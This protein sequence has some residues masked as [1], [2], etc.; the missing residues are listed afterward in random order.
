MDEKN[1]KTPELS[2]ELENTENL[3]NAVDEK[4]TTPA[5]EKPVAEKATDSESSEMSDELDEKS[6][7]ALESFLSRDTSDKK[8]KDDMAEKNSS[9]DTK[10]KSKKDKKKLKKSTKWII[11]G[12]VAA[13]ILA[14]IICLLVFLPKN[15]EKPLDMGTDVNESVSDDGM[16]KASVVTDENGKIANNSFGSL[17]EYTPS[18]ITKIEVEN[19]TGSF[20]VKAETK[21]TKDEN[22]EEKTD[23]TVYTVEGLENIPL[24]SG[25]PDAIANDAAKLDF[26]SVASLNPKLSDF[27]LESP[28]ATVKTTFNDDTYAIVKVGQDAPQGLGTYI[29][30]GDSDT[31]YLVDSES[32]DA[33][34][35]SVADLVSKTVTENGEGSNS[36]EIQRFTLTGS[37]FPDEIVLLPN[38]DEAIDSSYIMTSPKKMFASEVEGANITNHIRGLIADSVVC[39]NPSDSQ[40]STYG[41]A[42][43]YAK[44]VAIYPDTTITLLSSKPESDSVYLMKEDSNIIYKLSVSSTPWV[45]TSV[46]K[47]KG[48]I[49][50][51]PN[52]AS[53]SGITVEDP[54]GKYYFDV[55]TTTQTVTNDK[56]EE[57]EVTSTKATYNDKALDDTNFAVFFQNI[58]EIKNAGEAKNATLISPKLT[59][60]L[61]YS[62]GRADD[63]ISIYNYDDTKMAC[64]LNGDVSCLVYKSFVTKFIDSVQSLIKGE[65]VPS[66]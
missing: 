58:C 18:Q 48:D 53:V 62:T 28:R 38:E 29:T 8:E 4:T 56:D 45:T 43:P 46:D 64:A 15:E 1:T 26:T 66:F 23:A 21:T 59:I 19:E 12:S 61:S 14:G 41:L 16:H 37:A 60:T 32:V 54:S 33:F 11:F 44:A 57:E 3:E 6:K 65:T 35:S 52:K 17:L 9:T 63:V 25:K 24:E 20:T 10:D 2:E 31:V 5:D 30:F 49:V 50:L 55:T 7:S 34:L 39:V 22:G 40:K 51:D 47:L 27:G 42:T 13:L 36:S